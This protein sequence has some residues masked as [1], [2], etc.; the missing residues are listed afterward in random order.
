MHQAVLAVR[1]QPVARI[2]VS[3]MMTLNTLEHKSEPCR[4]GTI[5]GNFSNFRIRWGRLILCLSRDNLKLQ[6]LVYNHRNWQHKKLSEISGEGSGELRPIIA[7]VCVIESM[8]LYS[9]YSLMMYRRKEYTATLRYF[10]RLRIHVICLGGVYAHRQNLPGLIQDSGARYN[11]ILNPWR[12]IEQYLA[13]SLL[14]A[15]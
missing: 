9:Q 13:E 10:G 1:H 14:H 11:A 12:V 8:P 5:E 4:D 6:K 2:T 3:K 7:I 15:F